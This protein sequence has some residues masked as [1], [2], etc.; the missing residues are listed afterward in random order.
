MRAGEDLLLASYVDSDA[1]GLVQPSITA[2]DLQ[3]REFGR[4]CMRMLAGALDGSV[5]A[6]RSVEVP[7]RLVARDSTRRDHGR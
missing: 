6:G 7:I 2:L 4:Q 3:P 1:L 5:Q